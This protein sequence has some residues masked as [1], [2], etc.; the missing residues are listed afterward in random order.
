MAKRTVEHSYDPKTGKVVIF[1][2]RVK[3]AEI[4]WTKGPGNNPLKKAARALW[5]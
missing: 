5:G 3:T 2:S 1:D 4:G